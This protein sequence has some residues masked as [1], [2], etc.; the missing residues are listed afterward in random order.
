MV[1]VFGGFEDG[2]I[3]FECTRFEK[4]NGS[5]I[6]IYVYIVF[7]IC[8]LYHICIMVNQFVSF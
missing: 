2:R 7:V 8:I 1:R 5:F 4:K 3:F 6:Y